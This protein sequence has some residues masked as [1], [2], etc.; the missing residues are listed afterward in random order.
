ML[1]CNRWHH[2]CG[3]S[4]PTAEDISY[5]A[6]KVGEGLTFTVT[7]MRL[8]AEVKWKRCMMLMDSRVLPS[9]GLFTLP[10]DNVHPVQPQCGITNMY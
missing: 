10:P 6:R 3:H 2:A 9:L 4:T 7:A 1:P 8:R 5:G